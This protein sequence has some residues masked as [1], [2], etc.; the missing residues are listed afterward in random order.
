MKK[1]ETIKKKYKPLKY[2]LDER[3]RRLLAAGEAKIL[4]WV[5]VLIISRA[6]GLSLINITAGMREL[7]V[8]FVGQSICLALESYRVQGAKGGRKSLKKRTTFC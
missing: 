1:I 5:D 6:T 3:A 8:L 4:N 2:F 7:T